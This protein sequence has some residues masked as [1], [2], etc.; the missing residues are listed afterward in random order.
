V[1]RVILLI[2]ATLEIAL[3]NT[4]SSLSVVAFVTATFTDQ[5]KG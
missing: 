2:T 5:Q 4:T 1:D 3:E